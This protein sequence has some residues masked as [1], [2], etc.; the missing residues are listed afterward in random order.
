VDAQVHLHQEV[1]NQVVHNFMT[2]ACQQTDSD[3]VIKI[4]ETIDS[5]KST[6]HDEFV[7]TIRKHHA[8]KLLRNKAYLEELCENHRGTLG[9]LIDYVVDPVKE[10]SCDDSDSSDSSD[11]VIS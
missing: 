3:E 4:M 7:E 9:R 10:D 8:V 6:D 11:N 2:I 5:Y 1:S